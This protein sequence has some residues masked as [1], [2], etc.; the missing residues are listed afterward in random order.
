LAL[1]SALE[2]LQASI[3]RAKGRKLHTLY[4]ET[5]PLR[6]ELYPKHTAF[7]AAPDMERCMMAANRIGK[8]MGV[9]GYETT[10]HLTGLYPEWWPGRRF[11]HPIEAWVAGDTLTTTRDI[12]QSAL[13]GPVGEFGTGLIPAECLDGAPVMKSGVPGGVD[14]LRVKHTSGRASLLGFKSYD[15]GRK[16]FQGTAKHVVWLDEEPSIAVYDECMMRLVTT[17]GL[18]IC[19]FTP[20]LGL[21]DVAL[22][23]L[24]HLAPSTSDARAQ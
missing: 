10:L 11:E 18:M 1:I 7:F 6:R 21:S 15:Q 16:T 5:G 22:R 19:T 3:K 24:P 9:G 17:Q 2:S 4:P 20:L 12:V 8:T 14:F 13:L 23:F